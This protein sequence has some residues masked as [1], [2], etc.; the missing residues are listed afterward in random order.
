[1]RQVQGVGK[2]WEKRL[3]RYGA[4]STCTTHPIRHSREGGNPALVN[5]GLRFWFEGRKR[6]EWPR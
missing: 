5:A 6:V 4:N 3:L 1:M 2:G